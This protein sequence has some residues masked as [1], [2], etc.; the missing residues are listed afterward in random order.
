MDQIVGGGCKLCGKV[1]ASWQVFCGATC[2]VAWEM[3]VRSPE[4]LATF[5]NT[6]VDEDDD[7]SLHDED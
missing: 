2:S 4:G 7:A 5:M 1:K 3:G 6:D